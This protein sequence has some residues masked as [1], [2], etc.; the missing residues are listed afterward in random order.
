MRVLSNLCVCALF[1]GIA[2]SELAAATEYDCGPF[3][4]QPG[5]AAMTIVV[6]HAEPVA[7]TLTWQRADGKGK[8]VTATHDAD[9]HH[10]F[11][12][13]GLK[14]DTRYTYRL[15]GS[16][17]DS[18][19]REFHTLPESPAAY[20]FLALGDVRS[21]PDVWH[22]V[23]QR[24]YENESDA[25]FIVGTGDYPA[26][27]S[28][29]DQ[30]IDQFFDPARDLLGRIPLWPA[31]GNHE[32]TRQFV[33]VPP[34]P[35]QAERSHYFSLF[36]LPG[37]EHW[38]RVDYQYLTLLIIDSN[39]QLAPGFEQYEW[40]HEQLRSS[41]NRYTVAAF[42]HAPLTSGPH[43]RRQPD[44]TPREWP[45]DQGQR[46]LMPLFEMY[47]VDLVLNGHD[48]IYER[49]A[50]DGVTYVVTGGGGAPLYQINSAENRYQQVAKSTN[51]YLAIDVT[52]AKME[53][54]A[55]DAEGE[56][57]DQFV[58][59]VGRAT[60]DRM[61]SGW[62]QQLMGAI[63]FSREGEQS[64]VVLMNPL[65]FDVELSLAVEGAATKD[66]RVPSGGVAGVAIDVIPS[67][68]D[69]A[70][71][72]WR[73]AISLPM[74]VALRGEG[75]GIPL[76]VTMQDQAVL[77]EAFYN[78]SPMDTPTLDGDLAEWSQISAMII[79]AESRTIV[80]AANYAGNADMTAY[81]QAGWSAAGLHLSFRVEDE[82]VANSPGASPWGV[83]GVEIYID[84]RAESARTASYDA[85][86]SQNVLPALR[87]D[88]AVEGTN[89][90]KEGF[91]WAAKRHDG[92][93]TLE[94]TVP[95]SQIRGDTQARPAVGDIVRFDAMINDLDDGR[96][97]HHR[98]W[99]TGGASRD[100]SGFGQ[101]LLVE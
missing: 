8:R 66:V 45:V 94:I 16:G 97:S 47:G 87:P 27:G 50:K 22:K 38:Y 9:R 61:N 5:P 41:R 77:R 67:Q 71:P 95:F 65:D 59:P 25:L 83:D 92:G 75:D 28:Q 76:D 15:Q 58:V 46:F 85:L 82:D 78:V 12:L 68:E 57:I 98:L 86:V 56:I 80:S 73:G 79:D 36:E 4:L 89:A 14:P 19:E 84:G 13:D 7:A 37:N 39:S 1:S 49:S 23:S 3:L 69:L 31:I 43:G 60:R 32:R 21:L 44:G 30:W 93:Y 20:R 54:T 100:P 29:Y 70:R 63:E 26:D 33:T 17:L 18:G 24:I 40:L 81:V 62:S 52:A 96:V 99:S 90:W 10:I 55:I 72:A 88:D 34:T 42:H 91:L 53:A 35:E 6:D 64:K 51:H 11:A 48:H 74:T 101:L 2:V